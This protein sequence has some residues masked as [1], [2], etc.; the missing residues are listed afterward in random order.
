MTYTTATEPVTTWT[1][2]MFVRLSQS[3]I[4]NLKS[5]IRNLQSAIGLRLSSQ[6]FPWFL[7]AVSLV[8]I[9][10]FKNINLLALLGNVMLVLLLLNALVVGRRLGRLE[11]RRHLSELIFAGSGCKVELR[12]RNLSGRARWG[13]RVEDSG[14]SHELGWYFDRL[15]GHSVQGLSRRDRS[16]PARLV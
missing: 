14:A 2:L 6:G 1:P 9:G 7:T 10:L 15:E 8:S 13:V 5:A 11:A 4:R 16:T 3:A 12:M